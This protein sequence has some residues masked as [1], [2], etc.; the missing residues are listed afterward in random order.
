[1]AHIYVYSPSGRVADRY[2]LRRGVKRLQ[3]RGHVVTLDD[4]VLAGYQR[5]A[6]TDAQ[7]LAA[8]HRAANS[9][10]TH[11][12][13]TT[14]ISRGGY[15]LTR[16]LPQLDWDAIAR[17][18]AAGVRWMGFSDF[19]ALQLALLAHTGMHPNTDGATQA[20]MQT[21]AGVALC[22]DYGMPAD[23]APDALTD[24]FV[25]DVLDGVS[26]GCGWRLKKQ[27]LEQAQRCENEQG[28]L[29]ENAPLWGGNLTVL[30]ALLG[31]PFF[32][33]VE[34]GILFL[35][36]VAEHPYRVER[37]LMQ[38][39]LAGVLQ[40]QQMIVLGDF[41]GYTL[42]KKYERGFSMAKVV[43]FVREQLPNV[44]VFTGLPFGHAGVKVSLPVGRPTSV[45][46]M[47]RELLLL[48]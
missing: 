14:L 32:P 41:S 24:A 6:G 35:E 37:A 29:V 12:A 1:M 26:E 38:L 27:E 18:V 4:A 48:W 40:R 33:L 30:T 7:R 42:S 19:T 15:G 2:A 20:Q 23:A 5:F 44:P 36:D 39:H 31:T 13:D 47:G 17:S 43:A 34:G 11:G 16:L 10:I 28:Y 3:E 25:H 8:V 22:P 21:W 9:H 46:L 45:R